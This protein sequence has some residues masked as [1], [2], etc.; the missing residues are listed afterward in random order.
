[1]QENYKTYIAKIQ[2]KKNRIINMNQDISKNNLFNSKNLNTTG[3]NKIYIRKKRNRSLSDKNKYFKAENI[4]ARH[5]NQS[6]HNSIFN[7]KKRT[8]NESNI[9]KENVLSGINWKKIK[10]LIPTKTI[11]EVKSFALNFFYKMKSFKD[12]NLGLD[13][14]LNSVNNLKDMLNQIYFKYPNIIDFISIFKK[15]LTKTVRLRKFKKIHKINIK[16]QKSKLDKNNLFSNLN[17]QYLN[18]MN[19]NGLN[20]QNIKN[21]NIINNVNNNFSNNNKIIVFNLNIIENN[22]IDNNYNNF[23]NILLIKFLNCIIENFLLSYILLNNYLSLYLSNDICIN[24]LSQINDLLLSKDLNSIIS[25]NNIFLNNLLKQL[26]S[27]SNN[28]LIS[29]SISLINNNTNLNNNMINWFN[30]F[31]YL[32]QMNQTKNN[33]NN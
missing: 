19:K 18:N 15:L 21:F 17:S 10:T 5:K 32:N 31:N 11:A 30:L 4:S 25:T 22:F 24:Y 8:K 13:F 7:N 28:L 16:N 6:S 12:N 20:N 27:F 23:V 2:I 26:N 9:F 3:K 1:M 14:T 29:N 33:N